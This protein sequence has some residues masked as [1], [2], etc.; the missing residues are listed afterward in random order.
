MRTIEKAKPSDLPELLRIYDIARDF[1]RKTGNPNQWGSGYPGEETLLH[2]ISE[3]NL[4][5]LKADG[6]P[7][8]AFVLAIGKEPNYEKIDNGAWL[9]DAEYGTIHRVASDGRLTGVF[10]DILTFCEHKISHL[11]IDTH[12]N[13]LIMQKLIKRSGFTKCGIIYIREDGTPRIAYEKV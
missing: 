13:N 2:D 4:Y 10:A 1:M 12:R 3:G 9:S 7:S 6:F 5:V 11:R 8:A